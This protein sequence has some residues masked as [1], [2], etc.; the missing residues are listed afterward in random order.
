MARG[1]FTMHKHYNIV[2]YM[3]YLCKLGMPQRTENKFKLNARK[4]QRSQSRATYER[5][6]TSYTCTRPRRDTV[7]SLIYYLFSCKYFQ[8]EK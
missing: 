1:T 6:F 8:R 7:L 3:K 4:V 2:A 5:I